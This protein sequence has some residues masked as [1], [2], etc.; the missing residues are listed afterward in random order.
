MAKEKGQWAITWVPSFGAWCK[1]AKLA[2][3]AYFCA[4][5]VFAFNVWRFFLL[6]GIAAIAGAGLE[7]LGFFL[8]FSLGI[9]FLSLIWFIVW[10]GVYRF[11]LKVL[12]SNPP[13]WLKLPSNSTM[14][15]RDFSILTL[16]TLPITTIFLL[17]VAFN[18]S[19][20]REFLST[21]SLKLTYDVFLLKFSWLWFIC[22]A[23]LYQQ[24]DRIV[25]NRSRSSRR[26][27]PQPD[28][29]Q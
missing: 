22:A 13:Q 27:Y 2:I 1:A 7:G 15:K 18:V 21:P 10:T 28:G 9:L 11:L 3:P 4:T 23:C 12:W 8:L 29:S 25:L 6:G 17:Y 20:R 26:P 5:V 19:L 24:W 14:A 16:S